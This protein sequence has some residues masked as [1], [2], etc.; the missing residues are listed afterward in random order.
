MVFFAAFLLGQMAEHSEWIIL[1]LLKGS[2][3]P[4]PKIRS[5]ELQVESDLRWRILI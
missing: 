5:A 3:S 4:A 2:A 1:T